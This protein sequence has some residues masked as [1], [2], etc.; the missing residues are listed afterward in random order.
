MLGN[1][2]PDGVY[3]TIWKKQVFAKGSKQ[4]GARKSLMAFACMSECGPGG[5]AKHLNIPMAAKNPG[6]TKY[7]I[8]KLK[9]VAAFCPYLALHFFAVVMSQGVKMSV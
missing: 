3:S 2:N 6:L 8:S 7:S 4:Y 5:S 9:N 1:A